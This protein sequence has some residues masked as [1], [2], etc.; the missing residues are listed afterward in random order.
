MKR[1]IGPLTWAYAILVGGVL[2][3]TP[4]GVIPVVYQILGVAGIGL[5]AAGFALNKGQL[6]AEHSPTH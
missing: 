4:E 6:S 1:L 3:I 2:L 5:G